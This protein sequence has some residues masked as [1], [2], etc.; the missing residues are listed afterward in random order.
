MGIIRGTA[1]LALALLAPGPAG[2]QAG[3]GGGPVLSFII[4][5][6][7]VR[8][9][10]STTAGVVTI[11]LVNRGRR[12]HLRQ[13]VLITDGHSADEA[14][15]FLLTNDAPP[16]S[17]LSVGVGPVEAGQTIAVTLKLDPGTYLLFDPVV[18]ARGVKNFRAGVVASIASRGA[19]MRD[20]PNI[21]AIAGVMI[22]KQFR[23][24]NLFRSGNT[25]TLSESRNR[26]TSMPSGLQTI[27]IE[28]TIPGIHSVVLAR[29][30]PEVM[31]QYVAWREGRRPAPPP[32]LVGGVAGVPG[33]V[34]NHRTFLQAR[35]AAGGYILFCP[36]RDART[37]LSGFETGEFTQFAVQ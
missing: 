13:F 3:A 25:W 23:F 18:D 17:P 14:K 30:G 9:P 15:A 31:R 5:D 12:V 37:G 11:Q 20:Q 10:P 35:L 21:P 16:P 22:G 24:G 8:G 34:L 6:S 26:N 1:L 4:S 36:D 28:S 7:A 32:G 19:L 2:T 27:R 33:S 29:G